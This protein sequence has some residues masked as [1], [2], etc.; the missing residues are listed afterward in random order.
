MTV[1]G[2]C[3]KKR[4]VGVSPPLLHNKLLAD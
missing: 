4:K 2:Q 3:I 1:F